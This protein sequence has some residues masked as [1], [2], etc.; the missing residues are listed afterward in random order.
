LAAFAEQAS[1]VR[2]KVQGVY[3]DCGPAD[4]LDK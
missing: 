1:D 2:A 4:V 3:S